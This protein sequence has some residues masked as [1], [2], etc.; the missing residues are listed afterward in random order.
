M[1][2]KLIVGRYCA[3]AG[4]LLLRT[5]RME[6]KGTRDRLLDREEKFE[7]G[8]LTCV[9]VN[10]MINGILGIGGWWLFRCDSEL[11]CGRYVCM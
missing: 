9:V 5:V 3:Y 1:E 11:P 8:C 6:Y 4:M 2:R 10:K 7:V